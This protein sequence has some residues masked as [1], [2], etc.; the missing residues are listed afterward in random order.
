MPVYVN[1]GY[2]PAPDGKEWKHV[3]GCTVL[4]E[5]ETAGYPIRKIQRNM[6]TDKIR[7]AEHKRR[8]CPV[9]M[10]DAKWPQSEPHNR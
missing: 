10:S 3:E 9:C 4:L 5:R 7:Y 8:R 6:D 2:Q 1:V